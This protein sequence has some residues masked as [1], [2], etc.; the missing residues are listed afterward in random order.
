LVFFAIFFFHNS[1]SFPSCLTH[2]DA[3]MKFPLLIREENP[4]LSSSS[5]FSST[6]ELYVQ[7]LSEY[8]VK[9]V[10]DCL[11]LLKLAEEHRMIRETVMNMTSSRSHSIFQMNLEYTMNHN[12][13]TT[14][15]VALG[16]NNHHY[17]SL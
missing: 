10:Q 4:S 11:T 9:S 3:Q 5:S 13:A 2:S 16:N 8:A 12:L 17:P 6:K 15:S 1:F 14:R 7:G